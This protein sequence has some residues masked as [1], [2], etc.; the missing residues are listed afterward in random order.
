M[1]ID[2][3]RKVI[4]MVD[5]DGKKEMKEIEQFLESVP[6]NE[7]E[8]EWAVMYAAGITTDEEVEQVAEFLYKNKKTFTE[9]VCG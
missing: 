3:T 4:I 5:A 7:R 8:N 1:K 2:K 6:E 9:S